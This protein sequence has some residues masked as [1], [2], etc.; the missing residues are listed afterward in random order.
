MSRRGIEGVPRLNRTTVQYLQKSVERYMQEAR[1]LE[2]KRWQL[3]CQAAFL[4][5]RLRLQEELS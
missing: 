3:L 2:R 4:R 5:E 1:K